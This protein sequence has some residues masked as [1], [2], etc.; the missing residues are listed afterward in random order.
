MPKFYLA[1]C[2]HFD[3]ASFITELGCGTLSVSGTSNGRSRF[4]HRLNFVLLAPHGTPSV[5]EVDGKARP[6]M[7]R[8][9]QPPQ[10]ASQRVESVQRISWYIRGQGLSD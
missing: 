8:Q 4:I 1:L 2:E 9:E 3:P 5:P 10:H 6:P 7:R